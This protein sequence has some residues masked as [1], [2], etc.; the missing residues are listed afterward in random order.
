MTSLATGTDADLCSFFCPVHLDILTSL[1]IVLKND[2]QKPTPKAAPPSEP[3][4][5]EVEVRREKGASEAEVKL[6][7]LVDNR[8]DT[9]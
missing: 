4:H 2:R 5:Q 6:A 3:Q 9:I 1:F 7:E 8:A